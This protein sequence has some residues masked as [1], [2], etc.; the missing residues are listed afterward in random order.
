MKS[1]CHRAWWRG[2]AC[3]SDTRRAPCCARAHAHY[4]GGLS[5][6][7]LSSYRR[8]RCVVVADHAV[9][10]VGARVGNFYE[11]LSSACCVWAEQVLGEGG[12]RPFDGDLFILVHRWLM[13]RWNPAVANWFECVL[14][15]G[16]PNV[17]RSSD[18]LSFP[19]FFEYCFYYL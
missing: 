4:A 9:E 18:I 17:I 12:Q 14:D 5:F 13:R 16:L 8:C 15:W 10:A 7:P 2:S 11:H 6:E 19:L 3:L 1:Q